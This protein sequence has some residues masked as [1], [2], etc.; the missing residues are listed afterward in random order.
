[1]T[2]QL[3]REKP[4][5]FYNSVHVEYCTVLC[6]GRYLETLCSGSLTISDI[7]A[8]KMVSKKNVALLAVSPRIIKEL[9]KK[10]KN[11]KS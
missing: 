1:M 4:L 3:G 2:S 10:N 8:E 7:S 5:T 11:V 9:T 6:R